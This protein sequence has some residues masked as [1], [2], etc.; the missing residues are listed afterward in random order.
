[1]VIQDSKDAVGVAGHGAVGVIGLGIM[2]G[3][4]AANLAA[5]G[6][7]VAGY[8]VDAAAVARAGSRGVGAAASIAGLAAACDVILV[9]LPD[10]AA[11]H[12]TARAIAASDA[13][14]RTVVE[15][16]TLALADKH[17]FAAAVTAAGHVAIDCPISGTG[18]QAATGDLVLY[19]SGPAAAI[20]ALRPL[21]GGFA[22]AV[23]DVG[24][25][26]NGSRMKFVANLLVAIHNVAA[27]E[28]MVF[29]MKA[30]LDPQ[31]I[32]DLAGAGAGGSRV[33]SLRAP[34][35]ATGRYDQA[36]MKMDVWQ[37]DMAVIG[38]FAAEIGAPTPL[39]AAT[40]PL[41][42][43]AMAQGLGEQDTAAVCAVLEGMAALPR[44]I[45]EADPPSPSK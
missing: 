6:W 31:Q 37:K 28:A 7:R 3:A 22:R 42:V 19:A 25:Y 41:Y 38:A 36:T 35:M 4:I 17:G 26:G 39:F 20:D 40:A 24:A 44:A 16:S 33:F 23:H 14:P 10:A 11:V 29:G 5:A 30:G 21:L 27:A 43:A 15:L 2:G 32:V 13:P 8:D 12:A 18:A 45:S 9:S 1:M 34:M